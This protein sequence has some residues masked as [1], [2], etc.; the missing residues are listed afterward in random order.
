MKIHINR[1]TIWAEAFVNQLSYLNVKH[2]CISPGSRS[3]PL[4][5]AF[6]N[7]KSFTKHVVIDER[8]SGFFALGIAK[9][10]G[11]PVV[12]VTTS[13]TAVTEL[14]SAIAEA[15][16]RRIPLIVCTADRPPE[17]QNCGNNQTI[18]Q[19]NI[20]RN[21][22]RKYHNPCM[23]EMAYE[24]FY[25]LKA[26]AVDSVAVATTLDKGPVHINFHFAKPLE[27]QTK[28]DYINESDYEKILSPL[29]EKIVHEPKPLHLASIA[30]DI[31]SASTGLILVGEGKYDEAFT[32]ACIKLSKKTGYIIAADAASSFRFGKHDKDNLFINYDAALRSLKVRQ[33]LDVALIL[34]FNNPPTSTSMLKY[35]ETSNAKKIV[36]NSSG[37][38][39]DPSRSADVVISSEPAVFC[40]ELINKIEERNQ[41]SY[42]DIVFNIDKLTA[43]LKGAVVNKSEPLSEGRVIN[44][45]LSAMP[46]KAN[47]MVSNSMPVRDLDCFAGSSKK[48]IKVYA[49]RGASG[50]DG[51]TS[52]AAGIASQSDDPTVLL[53]GDLA[54]LHDT[55]GMWLLNNMSIPLV[56]VVVDNNGG[57]VF[58]ML[59][60]A[61]DEV[62]FEKYFITPHN[63]NFEKLVEAHSGRYVGIDSWKTFQTE[64][65]KAV[66][67][68]T[69]SVL[70]IKTDAK[71]S[72]AI[73]KE[74]WKKAAVEI[75]KLL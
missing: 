41:K 61:D 54:F 16:Q 12:L 60:I 58:S 63:T 48:E 55:N 35:F 57:A 51:I 24:R 62:N 56:I 26:I 5:L 6:A 67:Q 22:V 14:H 13:G 3:T 30:E 40:N 8:S 39:Q 29:G 37:D 9:Q 23:P 15:Y 71:E 64:L 19:R 18:N 38:L 17:L 43:E 73:R 75:E 7:N 25:N 49:N 50:I 4:T 11:E 52:T 32:E 10:T 20:F 70:H 68:K 46:N 72:M 21:N 1:N 53:T 34:S 27:P 33:R 44:E 2:V 45:L 65:K 47:L 31:R 69:F 36:I 42:N 59:P 28:T 66:K 74:F